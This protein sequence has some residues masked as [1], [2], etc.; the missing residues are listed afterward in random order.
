MNDEELK[1][2]YKEMNEL[3]YETVQDYFNGRSEVSSAMITKFENF[4]GID[5]K[6]RKI[7]PDTYLLPPLPMAD[8]DS[9]RSIA[10]EPKKQN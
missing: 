1:I 9:W 10:V 3:S 6:S 7:H 8:D 5:F 4:S 2:V